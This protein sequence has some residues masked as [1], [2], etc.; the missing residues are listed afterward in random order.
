MD[1]PDAEH[2]RSAKPSLFCF[3]FFVFLI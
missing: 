3:F 2:A 1:V